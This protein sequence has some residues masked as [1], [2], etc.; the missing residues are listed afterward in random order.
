[1]ETFKNLPEGT[2]QTFYVLQEDV[3]AA[4]TIIATLENAIVSISP[5]GTMT[6]ISGNPG[7]ADYQE[8]NRSTARYNTL[9]GMYQLNATTLI[10]SDYNNDCLR[11][12]DRS[13]GESR[14]YTGKCGVKGLKDGPLDSAELTAPA[15]I[16][17]ATTSRKVLVVLDS[18]ND[19]MRRI[20]IKAGNMS[21]GVIYSSKKL[22]LTHFL[23]AT[24][25][26][27]YI[28]AKYTVII[29]DGDGWENY[30]GDN[31]FGSL[32]STLSLS[33]YNYLQ[34][35]VVFRIESDI[36][37]V[38]DSRNNKLRKIPSKGNV[39]SI[40]TGA[41]RYQDGDINSCGLYRPFSLMVMNGM[42]YIGESG[43]LGGGIRRLPVRGLFPSKVLGA[44]TG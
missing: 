31:R 12:V 37:I 23:Q 13:T 9:K 6:V 17:V 29:I 44:I 3:Y 16:S 25:G 43:L 38:A 35:L 1:M 27:A 11:T 36:L 30:S 41:E 4:D 34:G 5:D 14:H 21:T 15:G 8:G 39:S 7:E 18:E 32:D 19:R 40:C 28:T 42:L 26:K 2:F 33:R 20:D 10:V 22:F 24:P